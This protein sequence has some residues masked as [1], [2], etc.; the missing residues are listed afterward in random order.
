MSAQL[1]SDDDMEARIA[2]L[3]GQ[4]HAD[5]DPE[6]SYR[7]IRPLS[8][9]ADDYV[10][11]VQN[12][13]G[14]WLF[15]IQELDFK[16]RGLRPSELMYITGRV[17]SGKTQILLQSIVN[18]PDRPCILFTY[19]EVD[20]LVLSKLIAM[21]RR[22]DAEA[23]E[24]AIKA[25]DKDIIDLVKKVATETYSKL[26]I[27]D[28]SL[29]IRQMT[30]A[31]KEAEDFWGEATAMAAI[32]Y[33]DQIPGGTGDLDGTKAK[34]DQVKRWT[35][36]IDRPVICLAQSSRSSGP[37]GKAAGLEA[38][39]YGGDDGATFVLEVFRKRDDMSMD[40]WQRD[41]EANTVTVNVDK[42]KRPPSHKGE[43]DLFMHPKYGYVR[44]LADGDKHVAGQVLSSPTAALNA[45]RAQS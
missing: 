22:I 26:L 37:R 15:G 4:L 32:D 14:R 19:D 30:D 29:N 39:R 6:N 38:M 27:V 11:L 45:Q 36:A 23:L 40:S 28:R 18:N 17:H 21:T 42:N 24:T 20:T 25:R 43:V 33:L 9:A 1:L 3:N 16:I 35:K 8:A 12:E 13:E 7:F 2:V 41:S 10:E 44:P 31:I 5:P 34:A